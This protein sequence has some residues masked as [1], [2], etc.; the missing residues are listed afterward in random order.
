ML[1]NQETKHSFLKEKKPNWMQAP[2]TE[3]NP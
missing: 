1:S 2:V 3:E